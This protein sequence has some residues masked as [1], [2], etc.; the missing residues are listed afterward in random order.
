MSWM[1]MTTWMMVMDY[2]FMMMIINGYEIMITI[3]MDNIELTTTTMITI[4]IAIRNNNDD[5]DTD[6]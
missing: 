1:M 4:L 6:E 3:M 2:K 5:N